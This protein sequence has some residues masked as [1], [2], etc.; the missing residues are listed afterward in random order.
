MR[1]SP[2][3]GSLR[4]PQG[5]R[6]NAAQRPAPHPLAQD[7]DGPLAHLLQEAH[8]NHLTVCDYST[9]AVYV[10]GTVVE[11]W[12]GRAVSL[13]EHTEALGSH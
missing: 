11:M 3:L 2:R 6:S 4:P 10:D 9:A 5:P 7:I 12:F 8:G 13:C 1:R